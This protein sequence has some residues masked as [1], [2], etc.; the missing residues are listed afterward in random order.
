MQSEDDPCALDLRGKCEGFAC[1]TEVT[2][3]LSISTVNRSRR[4]IA[5]REV[6]LRESL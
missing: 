3:A 1:T 6:Q 5:T 2:D 4:M